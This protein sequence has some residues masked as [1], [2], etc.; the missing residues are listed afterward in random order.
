[1]EVTKRSGYDMA[2]VALDPGSAKPGSQQDLFE[3]KSGTVTLPVTR[4][5]LQVL[6]PA[7]ELANPD[8]E[9][10]RMEN[11]LDRFHVLSTQDLGVKAHATA[12][13]VESWVAGRPPD[14]E[15]IK[16]TLAAGRK[17][18]IDAI[19]YKDALGEG[20]VETIGVGEAGRSV[21]RTHPGFA[22]VSNRSAWLRPVDF[23]TEP[24]RSKPARPIPIRR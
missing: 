15:T 2:Q 21:D 24:Y 14:L 3:R 23:G 20:V 18:M 7:P 17:R 9:L 5:K 10:R 8:S 19:H 13:P 6:L 12:E 22:D 1:M 4:W 16:S 11:A